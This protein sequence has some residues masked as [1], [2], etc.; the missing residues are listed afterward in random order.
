MLGIWEAPIGTFFGEAVVCL[1]DHLKGEPILPEHLSNV[2]EGDI[3]ILGSSYTEPKDFPWIE[4]DTAN[5]LAEEMKIQMLCVG[6]PGISWETKTQDPEPTNS[7]TH[8]AMTGNNIPITYPL[9]NIETL[10]KERVFFMSLPLNVERMEGTWVRA[11]AIEE[12]S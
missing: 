3:V 8:R 11:I 12:V 7:P 2:R 9:S 5:W 10:T 1:L 6:V 4:G